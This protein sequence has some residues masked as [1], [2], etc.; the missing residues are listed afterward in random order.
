MLIILSMRKKPGE[1]V[2]SLNRTPLN[3][4]A[5]IKPRPLAPVM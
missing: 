2:K 4:R 1:V 5:R 3:V